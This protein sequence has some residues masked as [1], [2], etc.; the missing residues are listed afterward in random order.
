MARVTVEATSTTATASFYRVQFSVWP[1]RSSPQAIG[2]TL[3][4]MGDLFCLADL[5]EHA[6]KLNIDLPFAG[7]RGE[8]E[9]NVSAI[10]QILGNAGPF[11]TVRRI[12]YASPLE[13]II[14][15]SGSVTIMGGT[16]YL[17]GKR[18]LDLFER[19]QQARIAKAH[20]DAAVV[21]YEVLEEALQEGTSP[22]QR[23]SA[24]RKLLELPFMAGAL[25]ETTQI[26]SIR[27][28][29]V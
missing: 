22:S 1:D 13:V 27:E 17:S 26:E 25:S 24:A 5:M 8:Y 7:L 12:A 19:W 18:I 2:T 4:A 28:D 11:V 6:S 29:E 21:A 10:D 15:I 9:E 14:A 20:A 23:V 16:L 3:V